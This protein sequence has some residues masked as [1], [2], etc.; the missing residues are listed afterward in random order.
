MDDLG[1]NN[2][3]GTTSTDRTNFFE[4]VPVSA[5]ERTLYLEADRMGFLAAQITKEMLERE[6][7]VVQ[8]EKRQGENQPYG[9]VFARIVRDASIPPSHPYSWSTI[10]SMDGP[11]RGDARGRQGVV[12]HLL[13]PEQLRA[14]AGRRHH[15]RAGARAGE[16]VLR[17]HPAGPAAAPRRAVGPALRAQ[18]PRRRCR[19]ACRRRASIAP[20]TRPAG[21]TP[22]CST[23]TLAASVLSGS[24]SARLDRRLVY[25][26]ELATA[27]QRRRR[28]QRDSPALFVVHGARSSPASIRRAVEQE[29]DAVV[30]RRS[31]P[32]GPTAAELQRARSRTL[33]DFVRGIERLGGF[34]GRSDVLAESMTFGGNTDAY[35][36]RLERMATATPAQVQRGGRSAGSTRRTTRWWSGRSRSSR[37]ARPRSTARSLPPLG[38]APDGDA[39]PPSSATTLTNGLKV[40]LL[41]RHATPIV[42]VALAV[43]AGYAADAAGQGRPG[44]ARARPARRRH[45]DARRLPRSSTSSTRSAPA[46]RPRSS[47]DLSFVRLQAL[48]ANL[49]PSLAAHGRRRAATRSFPADLVA[50]EKRRQHRA[51]RPG[52]GRPADARR[53]ASCRGCSTARRTPTASRSPAPATK[54]RSTSLTRDDLAALA[55][56]PGSSRT[57]QHADRHRRRDDGAARAGARA[58]R[59]AAGRAARR[60]KKRSARSPRTRRRQG[61]PDRQAGR[62]AVGDRRRARLARRGGQPRGPGDRDGDAQLRRHG[63]VAPQPQPAPRQALELRHAR[64]R[65]RRRAGQRPFFVVAPVQT[66]KTKEAMVEVVKELRGVAGERPLAGEEFAEHHAQPDARPARPLRDARRRSSARP[67]TSSASAIPTTTSPTTRSNVRAL[68]EKALADAAR[69]VHPAGRDRLARHRRSRRRSRPASAS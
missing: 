20:I 29:I 10:G 25:E 21:A 61:L 62:A 57:A 32:K 63:D 49:A 23:S 18:H 24:K 9:R 16:E 69:D 51:D 64:R 48:P 39:S 28:S 65:C 56:R 40:M 37:P 27:G 36:D 54:R 53:C 35:L 55:P 43:D 12:S 26:K 11:R 68:D 42:N 5:L 52:E 4:D 44:R 8:N 30:A 66:D 13:R 46:S 6:R 34:G 31:S 50:L 7:G 59:S 3:N 19:T 1:A 14:V 38:D 33:A 2:R 47:L 67:S 15:A 58:R 60:P 17:R 45:D 22:S 41:E